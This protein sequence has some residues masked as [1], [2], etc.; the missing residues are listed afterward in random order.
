MPGPNRTGLRVVPPLD[1]LSLGSTEHDDAAE[2]RHESCHMRP[3]RRPA[4]VLTTDGRDRGDAAQELHEE[5]DP[6]EED[7]RDLDELDEE[8][9]R[10][11]RH[12]LRMRI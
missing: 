4:H 8:E 9:D 1:S 2:P 3:E 12:D 10:H 11:Q 6:Q 7:G 5:P